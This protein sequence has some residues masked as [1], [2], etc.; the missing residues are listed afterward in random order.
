MVNEVTKE[1]KIELDLIH[2]NR[3][4]RKSCRIVRATNS[5]ACLIP[6]QSWISSVHLYPVSFC[7]FTR[8][9]CWIKLGRVDF[10][11]MHPKKSNSGLWLWFI[12]KEFEQKSL[13]GGLLETYSAFPLLFS[14]EKLLLPH[15]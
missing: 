2:F 15:P 13:A 9:L 4:L 12:F 11:C 10:C 5:S 7:I 8:S 3:V 1:E 14:F 6:E